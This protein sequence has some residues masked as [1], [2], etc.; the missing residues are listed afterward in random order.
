MINYKQLNLYFLILWSVIGQSQSNYFSYTIDSKTGKVLMD[1]DKVGEEFLMVTYLS[2]G[3]GSNDIGLDR[4]KIMSQRIVKFTKHGDKLLLVE[5]NYDYRAESNNAQER[6]SVQEAFAKSVIYGFKIESSEGNKHKID[7]APMLQEDLNDISKELKNAKQGVYKLDKL[8]TSIDYDNCL[9]FPENAEFEVI[10]TFTGE[11]TGQYLPTVTPTPELVTLGQHVSF[12]KLPD[13]KYKPRAFHPY[14][15]Y[16]P[17]QYYDY[18][19][20]INES[21]VKRVIPRHRLIKKNPELAQSEA[22][23]P[24]IYYVDNGCPEP[25][26]SALIEGARWWNQAFEAAGFINAFQVYELPKDAHPLDVRYNVIQ[27]VHRSTRGWSYGSNVADPRTGEIIKGHVSLGSLRVRQD[28]MIAQGILSPY[29]NTDDADLPMMEMSL[30]RLR[31][32]S[33]HEVGH[34]LGLAHNFS[35]SVNDRASVMDYPHPY[36]MLDSKGGFDLTKAYDV[37]I[38]EWD[39]RAIV[40]GYKQIDNNEAKGLNDIILETQNKGLLYLSDPDARPDNSASPSS[41]LW[42]NGKNAIDELNRI[43][44]VRQKAISNFGKA[45][46]KKGVPY[47][48]LEKVFV[49]VYFMQRYQ[50]EAVSK[51]IGGVDYSY[52]VKGDGLP[53][54]ITLVPKVLQVQALNN[55]LSTLDDQNLNIPANIKAMML[56]PAYG[57]SRT[58]ESF[59]NKA[60]YMFDEVSAKESAIAHAFDL[61]LQP[62][63]LNRLMLQNYDV[64]EYLNTINEYIVN[65]NSMSNYTSTGSIAAGQFIYKLIA[66][67]LD[68]NLHTG[69]KAELYRILVRNWRAIDDGVQIGPGYLQ[70]LVR[71]Y[72]SNPNGMPLLKPNTSIIPPGAPIGCGA[73]HDHDED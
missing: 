13:N 49:P 73:F 15:G 33:A 36:I 29:E 26:K 2:N 51:M 9:N 60:L 24:I 63:R 17:R 38:G 61:L 4:G 47:S 41:H 54:T 20:P 8:R 53:S 62:A 67:L 32:L 6:K 37:G 43:M 65:K 35:S 30:A 59:R 45:S 19:T 58:R 55:I 25:I 46:I 22:V 71:Q 16:F 11:S 1:V 31:Q 64:R 18:A 7:L 50:L 34:T 12:V 10:T 28:F 21:L 27:W 56:P 42:D 40:Y 68:D 69:V 14:S 66:T 39:K 44:K 5:P 48:E 57:Y 52:S 70:N 3:L 72:L 23:E